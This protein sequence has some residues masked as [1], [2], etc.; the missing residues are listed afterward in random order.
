MV[1]EGANGIG[2]SREEAMPYPASWVLF[3]QLFRQFTRGLLTEAEYRSE[4]WYL[5]V[6]YGE[7]L[8]ARGLLSSRE[9]LSK[10]RTLLG[11]MHD[12][13]LSGAPKSAPP[14]KGTRGA[15]APTIAQQ[16]ATEVHDGSPADPG[17]A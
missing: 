16:R 6:K 5:D 8:H 14:R 11:E 17:G 1:K 10:R 3:D 13:M 12:V 9:L 15:S 2:A 7:V 4:Q